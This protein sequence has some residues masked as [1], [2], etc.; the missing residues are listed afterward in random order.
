MEYF[1]DENI[2]KLVYESFTLGKAKHFFTLSK[3]RMI[4]KVL[5]KVLNSKKLFTTTGKSKHTIKYNKSITSV[6]RFTD[7]NIIITSEKD[8]NL[9]I[10]NIDNYNCLLTIPHEDSEYISSMIL[11]PNGNILYSTFLDSIKEVDPR[12]DFSCV[13]F[14]DDVNGYYYLLHLLSLPDG[15]IAVSAE[16]DEDTHL[17]ILDFNNKYNMI[18]IFTAKR[19]QIN[20]LINLNNNRFACATARSGIMIWT[21]NISYT[22]SKIL[23][24]HNN[25]SVECLLYINEYDTLVSGS[26]K[27]I[28]IWELKSY[29]SIYTI[30]EG[31]SYL[32][33]LPKG[34]FATS[35]L[36]KNIKIWNLV[37]YQCISVLEGHENN[38]T[39]LLVLK[40]NR[41]VSTSDKEI[42]IW[43]N[44]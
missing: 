2:L 38:I 8:A 14:V 13:N 40:D 26:S 23:K 4:S 7:N 37:S 11:L 42:I 35:K 27:T 21:G 12:K 39:F 25:D 6:T 24:G 10:I 34:Y 32:L 28:E 9:K 29:E 3:S 19:D 30:K 36:N 16:E 5:L 41:I 20:S 22:Y 31:A 18:K 33:Y 15:R 1:K 43:N 17:L 44:S